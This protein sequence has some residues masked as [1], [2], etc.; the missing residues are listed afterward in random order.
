MWCQVVGWKI[1][2]RPFM[3]LALS[4]M[5]T[6][7]AYARALRVHLISPAAVTCLLLDRPGTMNGVDLDQLREIRQA[8]LS[9]KS[10]PH[11]VLTDIMNIHRS[12]TGAL[13]ELAGESRTGKLWV[14]YVEYVNVIQM[15]LHAERIGD[16]DLHLYR[17][18]HM[19]PLFIILYHSP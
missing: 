14:K 2:G 3:P 1:C 10:A 17:I 6:G 13:L 11:D 7:H 5:L 18:R 4:H 12:V 8:L 15:F 9:A 19:I 16:W